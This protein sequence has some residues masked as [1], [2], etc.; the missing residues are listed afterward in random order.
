MKNLLITH[1]DLDGISPII[2]LKLTNQK[3]E[4]HSIEI[5]DIEKTFEELFKNDITKYDQ[6][7]ITDL[8][9]PK[10]VYEEL[11]KRNLKVKVFDH[12]E[13]HKYAKEYPYT[14]IEV[15]LNGRLTCGT[16]LFY[17]YLKDIY[18]EL[19]K[20][21]IKEYVELVR[22]IDTYTFT[23]DLPR[24][25]DLI[26]D[27]FGK[28]DFMKSI[29]KRLQKEKEH[30]ELTTFEKRFVKLKLNEVQR[31]MQTKEQEMFKYEIDGKI[32][33]VIFAEKNKSELGNYISNKYPDL[34]LVIL[35]DA[36]KRISY[37]TRRDDVSVAEF[38]EN[39]GGGGHQKASGS[40]INPE[41][42][43]QVIELY[44]KDAKCLDNN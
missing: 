2:L 1:N 25:L 34:D 43:K 32:C 35:I 17:E 33:G 23:D 42:R 16:E 5:S 8:T 19:N 36:S 41:L 24:Q 6:I 40:Y 31:Y 29:I 44:F 7:Y 37:R 10:S 21:N 12:H 39:Y 30:F 27:T 28:V 11:N 18:P 22:Q 20:P 26:R 9:V 15:S 38:A 13:S 3:F 14:T 4:Y